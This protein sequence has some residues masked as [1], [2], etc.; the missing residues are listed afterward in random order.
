MLRNGGE[1][2]AAP[3]TF[4]A[5]TAPQGFTRGDIDDLKRDTGRWLTV[6]AD[7]G[8]WVSD[9][10]VATRFDGAGRPTATVPAV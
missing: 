3:A 6:D 9:G 8:V 2:F 1:C 10:A 5:G 4:A 7:G